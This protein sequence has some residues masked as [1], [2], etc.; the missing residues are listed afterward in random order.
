TDPRLRNLSRQLFPEVDA[1]PVP[2]V[3]PTAA[4]SVSELAALSQMLQIMESAW[5]GVHL[6]GY[7]AH[8]LNRGWMNV[9][10]RWANTPAFRA[11]WP[12]L[13]GEY[14][15]DFV[16]FCEDELQ[17]TPGSVEAVPV[18][19]DVPEVKT[20]LTALNREFAWEWPEE[21]GL[22]QILQDVVQPPS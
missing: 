10:R 11:Y 17:L 6:E 8:P 7:A 16:R 5:L 14:G 3:D 9:F 21:P 22:F 4:D 13:R 12:V 20:A 1:P 19:P 15:Q 2:P 18:H